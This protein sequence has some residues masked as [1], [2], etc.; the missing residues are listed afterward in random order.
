MFEPGDR[1]RIINHVSMSE[2][3]KNKVWTVL[4]Y[5]YKMWHDYAVSIGDENGREMVIN[6][7]NLEKVETEDQGDGCSNGYCDF[8]EEETRLE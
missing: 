3:Q 7:K 1:V 2:K 8:G 4:R 6:V 5:P